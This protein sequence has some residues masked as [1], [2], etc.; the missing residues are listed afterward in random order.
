MR[1]GVVS[2][3]GR[4]SLVYAGM[5]VATLLLVGV[6]SWWASP[7]RD[8]TDPPTDTS[9]QSPQASAP[10]PAPAQETPKAATQTRRTAPT[11]T[12]LEALAQ[13]LGPGVLESELESLQRLTREL[14]SRDAL[15]QAE[16]ERVADA[17]LKACGV[18]APS[19]PCNTSAQDAVSSLLKAVCTRRAGPAPASS[20]ELAALRYQTDV[21]GCEQTYSTVLLDRFNDSAKAAIRNIKPG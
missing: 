19:S 18:Q 8:T 7:A 4:Q 14:S 13:V 15:T 21:T 2:D 16:L 10:A 6:A 17:Q 11:G 3:S 1:P 20:S 12:S 9:T 5:A